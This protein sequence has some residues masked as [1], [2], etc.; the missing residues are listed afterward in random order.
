VGRGGVA[1]LLHGIS[2]G[3]ALPWAWRVRPGPKGPW[4]EARHLAL[5]TLRGA[6][7]PAGPPVVWLG[8]GAC[9]GTTRQETLHAAGGVS[10]CRTAQRTVATWDGASFRRETLGACLQPGRVMECREV[11]GTR[12]AYG[13]LMVLGCGAKGEHEPLALVRN[14]GTAEDACR[15]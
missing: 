13:P 6:C 8:D 12:E 10:V 3:R 5:V 1:R 15:L 2:Q 14:L 9:D 7:L 4:P 11:S